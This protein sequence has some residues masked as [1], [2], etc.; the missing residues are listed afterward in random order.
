MSQAFHFQQLLSEYCAG[1]KRPI[2]LEFNLRLIHASR[3]ETD[4]HWLRDLPR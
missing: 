1:P 2:T 4:N 3:A